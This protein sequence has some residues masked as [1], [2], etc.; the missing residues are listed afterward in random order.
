MRSI[1]VLFATFAPT[2]KHKKSLPFQEKMVTINDIVAK[3]LPKMLSDRPGGMKYAAIGMGAVNGKVG[4][5]FFYDIAYGEIIYFGRKDGL[6]AIP[7]AYGK[8]SEGLIEQGIMV[9]EMDL[10]NTSRPLGN[11]IA[12]DIAKKALDIVQ[13]TLEASIQS[14]NATVR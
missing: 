2:G 9:I 14:Y 7:Q 3:N 11:I 13:H 12:H 8:F 6:K 10:N 5:T 1:N 4:V